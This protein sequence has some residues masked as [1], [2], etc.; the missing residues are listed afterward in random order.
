MQK[1]VVVVL[2]EYFFPSYKAGGPVQSLV[3]MV[4]TLQESY[5]F[6]VITT[7]FDLNETTA[8]STIF[9]DQWNTIVLKP[10]TEPIQVWYSSKPNMGMNKM[11]QLLTDACPDYIF[12]NGLFT[13]SFFQPLWL[14][15]T[16]KLY[17]VRVIVSPRGML[18]KGALQ[19]KPIRKKIYLKLFKITGLFKNI[20]WHATNESEL[21]DVYRLLGNNS[22]VRVAANVPKP[23]LHKIEFS[24]KIKGNLRLIYLSIITPKK[25]L[26]LLLQQLSKLEINVSLDIFGPIK[27]PVYWRQCLTFIHQLPANI[28]VQY[29]GD[30]QP[31]LVQFTIAQYDALISLTAG[32]NFGHALYESLSCGRP[33]ITSYFTPW[34]ELKEQTAGWNVD[35]NNNENIQLLL[36]Q[37]AMMDAA[38]FAVY[39][40]G[41]WQMAKNYY[42]QSNFHKNYRTIFSS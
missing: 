40:S 29:K 33:I 31:D 15:K 19:V 20:H 9:V 22:H 17:N 27:E 11:H 28:A 14:L 5:I 1:Q 38:D 37:I 6:K 41:A 25:N 26:L 16:G 35:I 7:A 13:L 21:Q 8:H 12:V 3:N 42:H 30:V 18:Q 34:N 10:Q 24:D 2:Y 4:L 36:Q 39:C 32:E 23:P